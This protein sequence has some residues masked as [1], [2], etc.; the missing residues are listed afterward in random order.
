[1]DQ[2]DIFRAPALAGVPHGF[3]GRRG[4]VSTGLYAGLNMGVGS[5]D[6]A[7]AVAEN[8]RRA[9]AAILPGAALATVFQ[10]HSPDVVVAA[11]AWPVADRPSA[12]AMVT[13]QP[14]L[15]LG[16]VTADCAPVLLA[17]AAAGIVGA[18]HAGW[19]GA[20]GGVTDQTIAAM[21]HLGA[22]RSRIVAAIGPCIARVSYEVDEGFARRFEEHDPENERFFTPGRP[23]HFQFDLEGYVAHRLAAA[24]LTQVTAL[25][26]DTYPDATRFFSFRRATHQGAPGYGRQMS[27]IGLPAQ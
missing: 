25:G 9:I 26:L 12:D 20:L 6:D 19:K 4:G 13:D 1:M 14:G 3:L 17:D 5:D 22:D 7:A 11:H 24:G 21:V 16:I 2:I 18:A 27:L 15:L 23:Q 8:R 10:V